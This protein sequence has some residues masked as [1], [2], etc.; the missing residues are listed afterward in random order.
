MN[1]QALIDATIASLTNDKNM[2]GNIV[3]SVKN[4]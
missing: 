2:P 1:K 4:R 3:E